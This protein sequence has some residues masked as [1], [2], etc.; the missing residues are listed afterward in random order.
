METLSEL[1]CKHKQIT[2]QNGELKGVC[3]LCGKTTTKGYKK[4]FG[5][6]MTKAVEIS[7]GTVIC[8]HCQPL[9]KLS[10]ELRR[11]MWLI[12]ESE[13]HKF[14]KQEAKEVILNLPDKPFYLYLT[15][16]WQ[17]IG[18]LKMVNRVNYDKNSLICCCLDYDTYFIELETIKELFVLIESLRELKIPK[19]ELENGKLSMHH[20]QKLETPRET[21]KQLKKY[22]GNPVWKLCVYLNE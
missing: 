15:N 7:Q 9:I 22:A 14:K 2:P 19:T 4:K 1:I 10:N 21:A 20:Y 12:T 8:P 3:C 13:F 16:T 17:Q 18:W 6:N 5:A 11:S